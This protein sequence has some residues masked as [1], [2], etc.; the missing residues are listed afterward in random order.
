MRILYGVQ[1]TGNGHL[2]R[3]RAMIEALRSLGHEVYTLF[4]GDGCKEIWNQSFFEPCVRKK[5]LTFTCSRGRI[6]YLQTAKGLDLRSFYRD[7]RRFRAGGFDLVVTDYEPITARIAAKRG[8]PSIGIGHLYSFAYKVPVFR[9]CMPGSRLVM[10]RFAPVDV[11]LGLHWH[12]FGQPILPPTVPDSVRAGKAT[13]GDKIVV[14]LPFEDM[15]QVKGFLAR[16]PE[17]TFHVYCGCREGRREGNLELR[18]FSREGFL[19]DLGDCS[20]VIC[21]AGFSLVSEALHLGRKVLAKPVAGQIEQESN[22]RALEMLG[23]GTVMRSLDPVLGQ[24]WLHRPPGPAQDYPDV[25]AAAARW[26]D[27]GD[28]DVPGELA[29]SLWR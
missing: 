11:P 4:S 19:E 24:E 7:I 10:T 12:H 25:I 3:S 23:L 14:Y 6:D 20:G 15:E 9:W 21:N 16:F 13:A 2:V 26:I 27:S 22:A 8:I 17:W 28:W 18:P 1:T 5:G 29:R